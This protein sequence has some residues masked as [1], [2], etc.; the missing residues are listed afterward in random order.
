MKVVKRIRVARK[1]KKKT[2]KHDKTEYNVRS[3]TELISV[4]NVYRERK[5]ALEQ[6]ACEE[7]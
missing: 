7:V 1:K 4:R 3:D 2:Y 6:K 5:V